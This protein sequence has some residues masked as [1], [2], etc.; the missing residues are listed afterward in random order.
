MFPIL[1]YS[2]CNAFAFV[3]FLNVRLLLLVAKSNCISFVGW[4]GANLSLFDRRVRI[5]RVKDSELYEHY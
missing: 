5:L 4:G 1:L 2:D 3:H